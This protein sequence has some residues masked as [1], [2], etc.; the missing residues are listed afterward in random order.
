MSDIDSRRAARLVLLAAIVAV[1]GAAKLAYLPGTGPFGTD[2]SFYVNVA[3]NVQEG[4]GL[5]TN[6]SL[7]HY[8]QTEL[9]T[10]TPLIYPLWPLL[11]GFAGRA[12]GLLAAVNYLPPL[13]Y[14][15][16]LI[17]VYMLVN[18]LAPSDSIFTHGHLFAL[19]LGVNVQFFGTTSFPYTE[20]L[21]FFFALLALIALDRRWGAA[22]GLLCG[23][24][25]LTRTQMVLVGIGIA[26]AFLWSA[27]RERRHVR[28]AIAFFGVYALM[29]A[30]W[31]LFFV[32][33]PSSP[34]VPLPPFAM[35]NETSGIADWL[36]QRLEGVI[37][38]LTPWSPFS[39]FAIFHAAFVLPLV[40]IP[41]ALVRWWRT[42]S[43]APRPLAIAC[44]VTAL[45]T[46][47]SLNLYHH[48]SGFLVPWLFGYRHALPMIF[49]IAVA[50]AYL[51][52][53]V[54]YVC[55]AIAIGVGIFAIVDLVTAPRVFT[56]TPAEAQM[57]AWLERQEPRP[58]VLTARAQHL[59][60]YSHASI[61]WTECRTGREM[62]RLMLQRLPIQYVIVYPGEERCEFLRSLRDL[63]EVRTSFGTGRDRVVVLSVRRATP[64]A[65]VPASSRAART[66]PG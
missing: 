30:C 10:R 31:Q 64:P 46:Y 49:G 61:H 41:V 60:A 34:T 7:Y 2:G 47:A 20:G 26:V 32:R 22:A 21:G 6:V 11:L 51:P 53:V 56:P 37:V 38:S 42:K 48:V 4:I 45:G 63:L 58:V 25:L 36:R 19:L 9:P 66:P 57:I 15:L 24:A 12:I 3:R 16:D 5:K 17:L 55:C 40:A 13:F 23:L 1:L 33:V 28:Q 35:W 54:T 44:A 14:V 43:F 62:T 59:S 27:L 18:R 39:Y 29:V 65:P 50:A 52:R 8:G